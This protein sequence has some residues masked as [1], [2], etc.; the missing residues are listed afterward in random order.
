MASTRSGSKQTLK[1]GPV[2]GSLVTI[3]EP[4]DDSGFEGLNL[5]YASST[6][7]NASG[8]LTTTHNAGQT[9]VTG[10]YS[11]AENEVTIPL[12]L[13]ANGQRFDVEW[14]TG[15]Q[16]LSFEAIHTIS[17]SFNDRGKVMFEV[18]L[19]VDGPITYA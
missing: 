19:A 4:G 11:V 9:V 7:E 17:R 14:N 13:G 18:S 12:L 5:S 16:T 15:A 3:V 10:D 8:G 6:F 1:I 2:N